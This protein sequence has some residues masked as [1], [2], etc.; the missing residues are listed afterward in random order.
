MFKFPLIPSVP[1]NN[2][3]GE[4]KTL[5]ENNEAINEIMK[6]IKRKNNIL[7]FLF[8][9]HCLSLNPVKIRIY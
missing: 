7:T 9:L 2:S 6:R 5:P 1:E 8:N 4:I 3:K